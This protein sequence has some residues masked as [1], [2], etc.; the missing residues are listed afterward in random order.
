MWIFF[1]NFNI[2]KTFYVG[3]VLSLTSRI[4]E[5]F[6]FVLHKRHVTP[7]NTRG[8][9]LPYSR[10]NVTF[11]D[12]SPEEL[13]TVNHFHLLWNGWNTTVFL[14]WHVTCL[15]CCL[16]P[17]SVINNYWFHSCHKN[18]PTFVVHNLNLI[19]VEYICG[20]IFVIQFHYNQVEWVLHFVPDKDD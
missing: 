9:I 1:F 10:M 18:R 17:G 7:L 15:D 11:R 12:I 5:G 8:N 20:L 2:Q 3:H 19:E 6:F 4:S 14:S 13:W 16:G